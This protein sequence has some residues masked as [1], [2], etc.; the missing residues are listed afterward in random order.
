MNKNG[1]VRLNGFL[2]RNFWS[3][4]NTY[5][6]VNYQLCVKCLFYGPESF[7][8]YFCRH[9][10][11]DNPAE[12]SSLVRDRTT[13]A[14][15]WNY[16]F[17]KQSLQKFSTLTRCVI[18]FTVFLKENIVQVNTFGN[19]LPAQNPHSVCKRI[20]LARCSSS[21]NITFVQKAESTFDCSR[22]EYSNDQRTLRLEIAIAMQNSSI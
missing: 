15:S 19:L 17:S 3:L 14:I 6:V 1:F 12:K 5:R 8:A 21:E 11:P 20:H 7:V 9:E 4:F 22:A 16:S 13:F 10:I 18:C 2:W